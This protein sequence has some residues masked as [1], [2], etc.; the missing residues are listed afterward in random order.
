MIMNEIHENQE[1][2]NVLVELCSDPEL[3]IRQD[4]ATKDPSA[5]IKITDA[6]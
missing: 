3:M 5:D 1:R 2:D 4:A 6:P